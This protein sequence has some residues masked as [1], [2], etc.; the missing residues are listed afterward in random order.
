MLGLF[1]ALVAQ[2]MTPP[3]SSTAA[4]PPQP[5]TAWP[6]REQDVVLRNFRFRGGE[7][8]PTLKIHVTT[9]GA[10][11]RN[12]AGR[13]DNAVMVLHGTGGTG[14]NSSCRSSRTSSTVPASRSTS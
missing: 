5:R 2:G 14:S 3:M 1:A 7:T 12:A 13:I 6:T 11:H 10:P 8:L 4:A 9:L